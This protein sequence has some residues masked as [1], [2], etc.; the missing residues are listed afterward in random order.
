MSQMGEKSSITIMPRIERIPLKIE[1][2]T[3]AAVSLIFAERYEVLL[4]YV[5]LHP[6]DVIEN[7][8]R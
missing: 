5:P 7:I 8:H 6:T 1:L 2:Y 3:G 4:H